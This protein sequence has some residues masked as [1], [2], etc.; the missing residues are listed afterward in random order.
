MAH[1]AWPKTEN[2]GNK[3]ES[4]IPLEMLPKERANV[5]RPSTHP[6][7]PPRIAQGA[8][9]TPKTPK[10][11][12][13]PRPPRTQD[14]RPKT[15]PRSPGTL[16]GHPR[17]LIPY[18]FS[19]PFSFPSAAFLAIAISFVITTRLWIRQMTNALFETL[20]PTPPPSHFHISTHVRP[21]SA[22]EGGRDGWRL[23]GTSR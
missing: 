11:K 13:H 22:G 19:R 8:P 14:P 21:F 12:G 6:P 3:A 15:L 2:G 23:G 4:L 20:P 1:G 16:P 10:V 5:P 18:L 9:K 7:D 17:T